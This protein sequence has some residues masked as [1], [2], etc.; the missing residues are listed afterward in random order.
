MLFTKEDFGAD[1]KW[2]VSTA[3]YQI[4]G[5]HI[6]DGKGL[7][8]WDT[9]A[10]KK[11][12]IIDNHNGNIACDFY[13]RYAEDIA[14]M[15]ELHIP[16]YRFSISWSRILPQGIGPINHKGIDFYNRIIDFCLELGIEP[17]ITLYHWDLPEAL[18]QKGGWTN[19]E[20][21]HWFGYFTDCCIKQFGDRVKH[22][23]V[24]NEPM[25]FTGAGYFLGVHAPGKKG[26]TN[27]LSAAHHA[28]LCQAEGGRIIKTL[29]NDCK[30]GTTISYSHIEPYSYTDRDIAAAKKVDALLNRMF[31]E[32]LL[33][34][35]YPTKDLKILQRIERFM[36]H[37]DEGKL[38]FDMDFIGL[39]N[40][41]R[42]LVSYAPF[43]PF[44]R[45]KIIKANKRNVEHTLM[46][47]EIYPPAIFEALKRIGQYAGIKEII[48]TENGAAFKDE[49]VNGQVNDWQ[50]MAY[51]QDHVA[52]VLL[53]KKEGVNVNGYFVWTLLDNFEWAEGF[54]PR[55]GLVYVDFET[56]Q[57]IVKASGNWYGRF[58]TNR[59][60]VSLQP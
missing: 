33:G 55:F 3:A 6:A 57:R 29:R 19:R 56:Q 15:Y 4:E 39:Q 16:N 27:F 8:I 26:L 9:F 40:Y 43:M 53:A 7:S 46:N 25:V 28:A 51:L 18:Q 22:W 35:G 31:I 24:L 2:G 44:V 59:G 50:R 60:V 41:T 13:N 36:H 45:A 11:K 37:G 49:P 54:H 23:M 38:A 1:F 48:V 47:W 42:E 34:M 32:P 14:L 20:V 12:K 17:W 5:A 52:Q 10:Q 58:L 21:I 30:V